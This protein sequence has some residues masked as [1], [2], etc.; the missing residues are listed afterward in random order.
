M[1]PQRVWKK[2]RLMKTGR[3]AG[4]KEKVKTPRNDV[5]R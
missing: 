5:D 1:H 3:R 4:N 2:K